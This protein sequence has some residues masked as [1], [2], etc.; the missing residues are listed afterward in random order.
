MDAKG[1]KQSATTRKAGRASLTINPHNQDLEKVHRVVADILSRFGCGGCGRI[2][3]LDLHFLGDPG[4]DLTK[5]G[6]ISVDIRQA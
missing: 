5:N 1:E 2:A 3:F 6:V 4:P